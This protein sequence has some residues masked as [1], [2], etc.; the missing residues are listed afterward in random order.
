MEPNDTKR[1]IDVWEDFRANVCGF[2]RQASYP[3]MYWP[4]PYT[5]DFSLCIESCPK[6]YIRDYYCVYNIDHTYLYTD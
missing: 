6:Y 5:L 4:D 3:Y 2:G 1:L